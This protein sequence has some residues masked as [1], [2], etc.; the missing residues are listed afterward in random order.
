MYDEDRGL[1]LVVPSAYA[2]CLSVCGGFEGD[3]GKK[4]T[5]DEVV[6]KTRVR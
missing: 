5:G 2:M 1:G 6:R 3:D 4:V